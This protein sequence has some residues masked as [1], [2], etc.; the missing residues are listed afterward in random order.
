M[1]GPRSIG[2]RLLPAVRASRVGGEQVAQRRRALVLLVG[3]P[4]TRPNVCGGGFWPAGIGV[5][6]F[7]ALWLSGRGGVLARSVVRKCVMCLVPKLPPP[8]PFS[9]A[10]GWRAIR[11]IVWLGS[12]PSPLSYKRAV[13]V[14]CRVGRRLQLF[15][16][17]LFLSLCGPFGSIFISA[18]L[19]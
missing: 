17:F 5:F 2:P 4:G 3:G 13:T 10:C 11:T 15:I 18:Y 19:F 16:L 14:A 1:I 6:W 9:M 8:H 7:S 12:N